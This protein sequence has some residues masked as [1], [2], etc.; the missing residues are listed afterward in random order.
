MNSTKKTVNKIVRKK[1]CFIKDCTRNSKENP[2]LQFF[3]VPKPEQRRL[4]C[5]KDQYTENFT[6]MCSCLLRSF[7]E[8]FI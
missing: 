5:F 8:R 2:N 1:A 6:K 4:K 7:W 3:C